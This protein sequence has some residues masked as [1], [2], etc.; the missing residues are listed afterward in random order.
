M[1]NPFEDPDSTYLVLVN[2]SGEH[3]LW[4]AFADVPTGWTVAHA[5]DSRTACLSYVD[6]NWRI[7]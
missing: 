2:D 5:E 6:E 1:P 4:P 7:R 3:S